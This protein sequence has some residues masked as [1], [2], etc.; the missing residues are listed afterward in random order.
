MTKD[1]LMQTNHDEERRIPEDSRARHSPTLL[2]GRFAPCS[3]ML[4]YDWPKRFFNWPTLKKVGR[5]CVITSGDTRF[6]WGEFG[7]SVMTK[8]L[9]LS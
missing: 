6:G 9:L 5:G 3:F 2:K 1:T 8:A 4:Y 7:M